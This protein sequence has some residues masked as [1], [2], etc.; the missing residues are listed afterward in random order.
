MKKLINH[1]AAVVEEMV[2][3]LVAV[4]P[5]LRRLAGQTVLVR[6]EIPDRTTAPGRG[7]LRRRQRS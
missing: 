3:G 5:G 6:A 2:E 7:D 1:P 4:F